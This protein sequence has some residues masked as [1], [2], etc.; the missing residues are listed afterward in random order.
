MHAESRATPTRSLINR[1][2]LLT[3]GAGIAA[4]ATLAATANPAAAHQPA[5]GRF[6][7]KVVAITGATSGI[8]RAAALAFAAEGA[9]VA[10]CGR[11][12]DL[13]G[14]VER[15]IRKAGG[16]AKFIRADVRDE[17]DIARFIEAVVDRYGALHIALNNAGIQYRLP[18]TQMSADEWDDTFATNARGVFLCIK[19]QA[20]HIQAAGGGVIM[21]TGSANEFAT[22]PALSAYAASKGA[23]TNLVRTAAIELGPDIRVISLAPGTTDTA[24]VDAWKPEDVSDEEWEAYKAGPLG[25]NV[26]GLG[27]IAQPEEMATAALALASNDLSFQTGVT[28]LVDGGMVAGL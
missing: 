5:S 4:A 24:L 21:V 9:K 1:R 20:P 26:D 23:V 28:V 6:T 3:G 13:G 18:I 27:R 7:D 19:H 15:E 11:R 14:Q 12:E 8:G 10:F 22:R 17:T 2:A 16:D 25:A